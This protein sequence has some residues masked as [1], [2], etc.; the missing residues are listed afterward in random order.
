MMTK[1]QTKGPQKKYSATAIAVVMTIV[2]IAVLVVAGLIPIAHLWGINHLQYFPPGLALALAFLTLLVLIPDISE[3][4][5]SIAANFARSFKALPLP[6]RVIVVALI[7]GLLFYI[8]RVHVHSL[9]DG[10]QRVYQVE[11]GYLLNPPEPFDYFLHA[12]LYRGLKLFIDI[13]AEPIYTFLSITLGVIFVIAVYLYKFP[14]SVDK[15]SAA[16]AKVLII[17]FGGM[18]IFFGYVESYALLYTASLLFILISYRYIITGRGL[19][20]AAIIFGIAITAHQSGLMLVPAMVYLIYHYYKSAKTTNGF[21]KHLPLILGIIPILVLAAIHIRQHILFPQYQTGIAEM[22][23]PISSADGYSI[24]SLIHLYDIANEIILIIP[25][26]FLLIPIFMYVSTPEKIEKSLKLFFAILI[27][28]AVLFIFLLD[29]KLGMPRDWDLFSTPMAIVGLVMVLMAIS[30]KQFVSMAHHTRIWIIYA[31]F[32]FMSVWVGMNSSAHRQLVRAENL[33]SISDRNRGYS[34]ELLAHYYWQIV[35]DKEKALELYYQIE[36]KHRSARVYNKITQLEYKLGN[37]RKALESAAKGLELDSNKID[38]NIL[39]GAGFLKLGQPLQALK[40]LYQ[41]RRLAPTRY[42]IYSYLGNTYLKLDSL[43]Q[44][45]AA[46]KMSVRL[47][48]KD[49]ACYFNTAYVYL[50]AAQYDSAQAY[51]NAGLKINP[52]YPNAGVYLELL[53]RGLQ[54][55]QYQSPDTP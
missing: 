25:I 44:A 10:Y 13:S 23:L 12:V 42:N 54:G 28:C 6:A 30:R 29:P 43:D 4:I 21:R 24:F 32:I 51:I 5:Y 45:L 35:D 20:L 53:K 14:V 55:Q 49:A 33:L 46:H 50:R 7:S 36:E 27:F 19:I 11:K 2:L 3:K 37:Y 48:P 8:F 41:A 26:A 22:L 38:L 15:S 52:D 16:M 39:A 47:N 40:F 31:P 9:G 17:T 34:I 18:Q 1:A